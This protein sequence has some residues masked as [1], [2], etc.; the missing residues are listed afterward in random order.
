MVATGYLR[1]GVYEYNQRDVR[2]HWDLILND[3]TDLTDDLLDQIK[4]TVGRVDF[5]RNAVARDRL[6]KQ[7]FKKLY[8]VTPKEEYQARISDMQNS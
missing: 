5:W 2:F 3:V 8:Q 4:R 6:R 7:L 1:H